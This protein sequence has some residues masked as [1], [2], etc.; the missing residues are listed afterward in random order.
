MR[1]Y[2]GYN[3][4]ELENT[5]NELEQIKKSIDEEYEN[6]DDEELT[7]GD[8]AEFYEDQIN[9][10]ENYKE[11]LERKL[12]KANE[13]LEQAE[14]FANEFNS[15]VEE[16]S[17]SSSSYID[18]EIES[19]EAVINYLKEN[20]FTFEIKTDFEEL[21]ETTFQVRFSNHTS[22]GRY[23]AES[24]ISYNDGDVFVWYK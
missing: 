2:R 10:L 4:M 20:N 8:I 19:Y 1:T 15:S 6:R 3:E 16:S 9:K 13:E 24:L 22:G 18:V 14:S 12:N 17:K 7:K 11:E 5:I 21:E 23:A